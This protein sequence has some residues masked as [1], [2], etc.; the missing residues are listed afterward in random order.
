MAFTGPG[1]FPGILDMYALGAGLHELRASLL[2]NKGFAVMA[3]AYYGYK[4]LPKATTKLDVEYFEKAVTLLH[5]HP[6]V[7]KK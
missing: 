1:P 6:K 5:T 4:D 2:A 3:L 7:N